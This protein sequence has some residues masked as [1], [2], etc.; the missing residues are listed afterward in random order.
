[1]S[2]IAYDFEKIEPKWQDYWEASGLFRV[3][4]TTDKPKYYCLMMFP[5]PS[6]TLH[7]GHG[8]NYILGDAVARYKLMKGFNVL[9]PMG[10]DA[11]GLPAENAA[12]RENTHPRTFTEQNIAQM[13]RQFKRWG[14]VYDWSRE[15]ATCMPEYYKWNQWLFLKL[16]KKGLA[17]RKFGAVNW[18]PSCQTVL[19]NEQVLEGTCERCESPV[20][21]KDLEQWYLKITD[22]AERLLDDLDQLDGWSDQAKT[23]QENWIGRSEGAQIDFVLEGTDEVVPV[24]TTRPDT[25][26]GV[27]FLVVAPEHP[28]IQRLLATSEHKDAIAEF[29][30]AAKAESRKDRTSPDSEKEGI[31]LHAHVVNPLTSERVP[32]WTANYALMEYGTGAVMGVPAHDQR[33]FLFA[34]KYK[35]PIKVVIQ[36]ADRTLDAKTLPAAYEGQGV[37]FNSNEFTGLPNVFAMKKITQALEENEAGK[38]TVT[39]RLR[40]WLI[41]RQRYWG[42]PIPIVYCEKCGTVPVPEHQLPVLLPKEAD[43]KQRGGASPLAGVDSFVKT[44]CPK[45]GGRARR[46][47]DTMDTFVDSSWYFLRYHSPTDEKRA[48]DSKLANAWLPVDMYIGGVEHA[49]KHLIYARFITKVLYD[50]MEVEAEEPFKVLFNQ[51]LIARNSNWC[52]GCRSYKWDKQVVGMGTLPEGAGAA[53][54]GAGA[55]E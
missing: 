16:F 14:V 13:R 10:W 45:C 44:D 9:A 46:E 20:E 26:Y 49:T 52:D 1:M 40:D 27:T 51:G 34:K 19:A 21:Q 36:P 7:V 5:Y 11:F 25:V 48:F 17:Y 28:V 53:G 12:I 6:G 29:V 50:F 37:Q 31:F 32:L 2:D 30:A 33:D 47:T 35:L 38:A 3:S 24:F 42:T 22:Y 55:G 8:R 15:I 54:A 23:L 43:F 41:S 39:Y 18:C 4:P